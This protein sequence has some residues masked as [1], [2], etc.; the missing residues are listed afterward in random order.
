MPKGFPLPQ[1]RAPDMIPQHLIGKGHQLL[2]RALDLAQQPAFHNAR[3][4]DHI[5]M[6]QQRDISAAS[7]PTPP[8]NGR[9]LEQWFGGQ[10]GVASILNSLKMFEQD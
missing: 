1:L 4:G 7:E 10:D 8:A 9:E 6:R 2:R 3:A 5:D